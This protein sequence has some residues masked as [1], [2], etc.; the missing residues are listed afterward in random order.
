MHTHLKG[1]LMQMR[2]QRCRDTETKRPLWGTPTLSE[3]GKSEMGRTPSSY[4]SGRGRSEGERTVS[5]K[6]EDSD[7]A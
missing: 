2:T 1:T 5:L 7:V 3:R 4:S 6:Q